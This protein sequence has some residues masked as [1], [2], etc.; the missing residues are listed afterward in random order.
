MQGSAVGGNSFTIGT[1][2]LVVLG[3][4]ERNV[5]S[6]EPC[7]EAVRRATPLNRHVFVTALRT[8]ETWQCI[9][10]ELAQLADARRRVDSSAGR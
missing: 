7:A 10:G 2:L 4:S 9:T 6:V 5:G 1:K 3:G 8:Q